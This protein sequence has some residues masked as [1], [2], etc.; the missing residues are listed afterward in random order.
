[1]E[2]SGGGN[3]QVGCQVGNT[4]LIEA[5]ARSTVSLSNGGNN[6][7]T[8]EA[9]GNGATV[10][11]GGAINST[12]AVLEAVGTGARIVLAGATV[13][14]TLQGANGTTIEV[15]SGTFDGSAT[16]FTDIG[17]VVVDAGGTLVL[18]GTIDNLG[19][20]TVNGAQNSFSA[21]FGRLMINGDATL[22][23]GGQVVLSGS[24]SYTSFIAGQTG[25]ATLTNVDNT[26]T[27]AGYL[28]YDASNGGTNLTLTNAAGGIIDA[29]GYLSV[30]TGGNTI[31]N[32]GLM[33]ATGGGN[34]QVGSQVSN[35]GL[36]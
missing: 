12:N 4:G 35:T 17:N 31:T 3:L 24:P 21:N 26:I 28:G 36:I 6:L 8:I 23:G 29:T 10:N 18:K 22:A 7:G 25:G 33:E 34:L 30:Y 16:P 5:L 13:T 19:T 1:M 14:G 15:S 20:I 9:N 32:A 2:A 27:G 11:L